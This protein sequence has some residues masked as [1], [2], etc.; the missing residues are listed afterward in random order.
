M[1]TNNVPIEA[2]Q[3]VLGHENRT[4]TEIYLHNIGNS[5]R[6]EIDVYGQARKESNTQTEKHLQETPVSA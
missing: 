4:N 2:I 5:E 3:R 1:D 6:Q